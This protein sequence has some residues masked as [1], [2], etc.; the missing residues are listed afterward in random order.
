MDI[1]SVHDG[2]QAVL[3]IE[4]DDQP[5]A[6][7]FT[8]AGM[9]GLTGCNSEGLALVVNNLDVLPASSEGLPVAFVLRGILARRTLAEAV[10]FASSVPHATG[11]HYGMA[12]PD[13]LASVEGWGTG[14]T[15]GGAQTR[16]LHTNHPL[17]TDETI[18]DVE[19]TYRRSRTR[20]R[21]AYL[22]REANASRDVAGV[23]A[24]LQDCTVPISLAA[25]RPSMT[26]CAVVYECKTPARMWVA[27]GPPHETAFVPILET[28]VGRCT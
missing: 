18:G 27:P 8:H 9:I 7:V 22:E 15:V 26:F 16:L 25:D 19:Q 14:A 1:P 24:M 5:T 13:G 4:S 10:V 3:R 20:E 2:T 12:A 6:L 28:V 21:L 23:Q 17:L 11:Q